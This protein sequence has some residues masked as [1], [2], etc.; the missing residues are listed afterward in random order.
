MELIAAFDGD[1]GD[2]DVG[3]RRDRPV[4]RPDILLFE[5]R[6]DSACQARLARRSDA[7]SA[8]CGMK[9]MTGKMAGSGGLH[10]PK[11]GQGQL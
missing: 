3:T 2:H 8:R 7:I 11:P 5:R 9:Q 1:F 4:A 6:R 10:L